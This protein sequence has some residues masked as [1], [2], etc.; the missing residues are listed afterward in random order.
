AFGLCLVALAFAMVVALITYDSTDPSFNVATWRS[1]QNWMGA[2]GSY[3]GDLLFEVLGWAAFALPLPL[4]AWGWRFL[5]GAPPS[6]WLWRIPAFAAGAIL[7]SAGFGVPSALGY[8]PTLA[9][10]IT[11]QLLHVLFASGADFVGFSVL[12][13]VAALASL[14]GGAWLILRSAD[15]DWLA[16]AA[17]LTAFGATGLSAAQWVGRAFSFKRTRVISKP[18]VEKWYAE[19]DADDESGEDE[20]PVDPH[21]DEDIP[22][23]SGRS[24]SFTGFDSSTRVR[25]NEDKK[26]KPNLK[27]RLQPAL[28][29]AEGEYQLPPLSLL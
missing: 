25:R 22:E 4:S 27:T 1:P 20:G 10:G 14:V 29:L 5:G 23:G 2:S 17:A 13:M 16:V 24:E 26:R 7:L 19:D 8:L 3:G 11:G 6:G 12:T 28:N 18:K 15:L 9:G 21:F